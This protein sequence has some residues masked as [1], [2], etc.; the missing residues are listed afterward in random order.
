MQIQKDD[1]AA[2]GRRFCLNKGLNPD[3]QFPDSPMPHWM[4]AAMTCADMMAMNQAVR[5]HLEN[6]PMPEAPNPKPLVFSPYH[7]N[8]N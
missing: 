4:V 1:L 7:Q 6:L 2:I 8:E 3:E 5:E